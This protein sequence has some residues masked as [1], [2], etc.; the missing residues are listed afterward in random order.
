MSDWLDRLP[1]RHSASGL[2]GPDRRGE[3]GKALA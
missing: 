2:A 1:L 3:N